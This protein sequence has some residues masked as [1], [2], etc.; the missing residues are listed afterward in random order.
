MFCIVFICSNL[1]VLVS[2]DILPCH[3]S[4][5]HNNHRALVL[6]MLRNLRIHKNTGTHRLAWFLAWKNRSAGRS[7]EILE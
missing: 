4:K 5:I 1:F 7:V 6:V 2:V 3:M